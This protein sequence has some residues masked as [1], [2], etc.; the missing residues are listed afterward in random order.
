MRSGP[1]QLVGACAHIRVGVCVLCVPVWLSSSDQLG[2]AFCV[3]LCVKMK[4]HISK[5][6]IHVLLKV[7]PNAPMAL[8]LMCVF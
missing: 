3:H 5:C 1:R 7:F 8:A 2:A 4:L 6:K